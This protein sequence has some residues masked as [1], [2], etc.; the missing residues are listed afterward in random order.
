M[1]DTIRNSRN[2]KSISPIVLGRET[3]E[4]S[5]FVPTIHIVIFF[6]NIFFR[7]MVN[8]AKMKKAEYDDNCKEWISKMDPLI[9]EE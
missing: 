5:E 2:S 9:Y 1:K 8:S 6:W 4:E 3:G 7:L